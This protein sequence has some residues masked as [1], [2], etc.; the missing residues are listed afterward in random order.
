MTGLYKY[1]TERA[2]QN[3]ALT[4]TEEDLDL[5]GV[6]YGVNRIPAEAAVLEAETTGT[7]G[8]TIPQTVSYV[9]DSNGARYFPD[10]SVIIA[11]G[12]AVLSLVAEVLGTGGNLQ[13]GDTLTIS[14]EIAGASPLATVTAITN[15]GLDR[16]EDEDYRVRILDEIRT[17]GGGSN[18]ADYR[19]WAQQTPGVVRA[20]PYTGNLPAGPP[21]YPGERTVYIK[22]DPD[23]YPDGIPDAALLDDARD[24]INN[25]PVTGESRP[26]LG[27]TDQTLY[28]E[29][30]TVTTFVFEVE[31]L[32]VDPTVEDDAKDALDTALIEYCVSLQPWIDGLDSDVDRNDTISQT[33]VSEVVNNVLRG[34]N[35]YAQ[36]TRFGLVPASYLGSY[37]MN[38]GETAKS[39]GIT[40]V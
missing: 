26:C 28:V 14:Q 2:L 13:I 32:T 25:D 30:I 35:G 37:T 29:P 31:G 3:L 19:T 16:E 27:S 11:G 15:L 6:N 5:I 9:G 40:Y 21:Y 4:A 8:V 7:N 17:V 18:A 34:F 24:Y 1:A 22:G 38:P 33:S 39:G 10:A 12:V 23:V 20:Y 36:F